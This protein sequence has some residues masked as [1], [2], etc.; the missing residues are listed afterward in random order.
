MVLRKIV[1]PAA[2]AVTAALTLAAC[3]NGTPTGQAG[4]AS[5]GKPVLQQ[6]LQ[7]FKDGNYTFT[8]T[9]EGGT[10]SGAVHLPEGSLME[11]PYGPTVLR[12]GKEFYMRYRIHADG[13]ERYGQ[14]YEEYAGKATAA[15]AAEIKAAK[16]V[17]AQL[18]GK[19]WVHADEKRLRAAAAEDDL[20]GMESLPPVPSA[21]QPD[22][23]GV[24]ALVGAVVSAESTGTSVTGTLDGTKVDPE[25]GLFANDPYYFYGP[26]ASAMPFEAALDGQ[27]RLT[28]ITVHVPGA[29]QA[30]A[31]AAPSAIPSDAPTEAPGAPL[32]INVT[33]YGSTAV[34][35]VPKDAAQL[36]PAAYG[37]LTNDVD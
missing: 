30:P 10:V 29:L 1:P 3:A 5:D 17:M 6:S 18:D 33:G 34:P 26:R 16:K 19:H 8:R 21:G 28:R 2:A 7:G 9:Q 23:T 36:D 14:L 32:V 35:A 12:S 13:Y 4:A 37:L 25:L 11:Q 15:Q 20:S 31:S 27:G 24:S 22:V